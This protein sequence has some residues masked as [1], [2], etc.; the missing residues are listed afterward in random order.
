MIPNDFISCGLKYF[1]FPFVFIELEL[2]YDLPSVEMDIGYLE[3]RLM[4]EIAG[5]YKIFLLI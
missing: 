4:R 3:E 5:F 1:R 2:K